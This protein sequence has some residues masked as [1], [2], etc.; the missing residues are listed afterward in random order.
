[1]SKAYKPSHLS[2]VSLATVLT[3][4]FFLSMC[5]PKQINASTQDITYNT[6]VS[7][8][9]PMDPDKDAQPVSPE[10][11]T[12]EK[13][14]THNDKKHKKKNTEQSPISFVS[15]HHSVTP[16]K[17]PDVV[18]ESYSGYLVK[19]LS[20]SLLYGSKTKSENPIIFKNSK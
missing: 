7:P 17:P 3:N 1:M 16:I 9:N 13:V 12:P 4:L 8:V 10:V 14:I 6:R 18:P 15:S 20:G 11:G 2:R 19:H 5:V